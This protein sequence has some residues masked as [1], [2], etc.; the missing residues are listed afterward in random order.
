MSVSPES[1]SVPIEA[2]NKRWC[3]KF[4]RFEL[5]KLIGGGILSLSM[6]GLVI[7]NTVLIHSS[8]IP[9]DVGELQREINNLK[10]GVGKVQVQK[11][12]KKGFLVVQS[13][14]YKRP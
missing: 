13:T 4:R 5:L 12:T 8:I 9:S 2:Q 14:E 11:S 3:P 7:S 6:I 1:Q 10:A